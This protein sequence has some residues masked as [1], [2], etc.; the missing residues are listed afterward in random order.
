M[1]TVTSLRIPDLKLLEPRIVTDER[2]FFFEAW[3]SRELSAAG[4]HENFVQDN[5]VRSAR[6][7]LRGLHYQLAKPQGKLVRVIRG[8]IFDVAVDM[9]G[10][11]PTFGQ[12]VGE[13]LSSEA[14]RAL[15]IP[16]GFAHGYLALSDPADV[17][18]K[19][20][21]YYDPADERL[22]RWNDPTLGIAWPLAGFGTPIV[23][24]RDA[25]A[26]PFANAERYQ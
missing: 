24:A 19:C 9:R 21:E 16:P 2:G 10:S 18:Y 5:C 23:A 15:W 4:F 26:P 1:V 20:T 6:G 25:A 3:N 7:V 17:Y 14:P 8:E 12:W 11:S 22:V 13:R